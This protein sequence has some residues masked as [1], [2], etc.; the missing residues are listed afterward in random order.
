MRYPSKSHRIPDSRGGGTLGVA[1]GQKTGLETWDDNYHKSKLCSWFVPKG[2]KGSK[3]SIQPVALSVPQWGSRQSTAWDWTHKQKCVLHLPTATSPGTHRWL[4][5]WEHGQLE[6]PSPVLSAGNIN[7]TWETLGQAN[8][9]WEP[10]RPVKAELAFGKTHFSNSMD[11][12][13][14]NVFLNKLNTVTMPLS[15][16]GIKNMHFLLQHLPSSD[17]IQINRCVTGESTVF[18]WMHNSVLFS[19]VCFGFAPDFY[20]L[21]V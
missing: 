16:Y 17:V 1:V 11:F 18:L 5:S 21:W 3:G 12:N 14:K 8:H 13:M 6:H 20:T 15:Q 7:S 10:V 4:E 9:R 2:S 19:S